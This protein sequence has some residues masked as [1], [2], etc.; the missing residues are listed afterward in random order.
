MLGNIAKPADLSYLTAHRSKGL[1]YDNVI[2]INAANTTYGFPSK[3]VDDPI[4]KLVIHEDNSIEYAEER[5]LFY[6]AM[7]RTKNRVYIA[8]PKERPSRFVLELIRDY[9]NV[10][11]NGDID[12]DR[13]DSPDTTVLKKCPICGY[14]LQYRH[15]RALGLKLW[16]CTNEPELCGFM[17]NDLCGG[18]LSIL[19]CD[20]CKDG[21]LVVKKGQK[22]R[23]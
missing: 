13:Q 4:I 8:A 23:L 20:K 10:R 5:R 7:T 2:V 17:T 3:I 12:I 18:K 1:G 15:K 11:V 16:L 9:S 21:Y 22:K 14:P 19:K 6:V